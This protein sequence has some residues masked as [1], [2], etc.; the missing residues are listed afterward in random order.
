MLYKHST[1]QQNAIYLILV[2]TTFL[3]LLKYTK[4]NKSITPNNL[5]YKNLKNS[6]KI[7]LTA[8]PSKNTN[9]FLEFDDLTNKELFF[10]D[11]SKS[12]GVKQLLHFHSSVT[13]NLN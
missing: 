1:F 7:D 3:S 6:I 13:N 12:Q 9:S 2:F 5:D 11:I 10:T 4:C 8:H